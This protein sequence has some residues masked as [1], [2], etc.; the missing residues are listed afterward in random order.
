MSALREPARRWCQRRLPDAAWDRR[1]RSALLSGDARR[2]Q[3]RAC[4]RAY[5]RA[6]FKIRSCRQRA[7]WRDAEGRL[8]GVIQDARCRPLRRSSADARAWQR[9]DQDP[10]ARR[11]HRAGRPRRGVLR[12]AGAP[13]FEP[14][15]GGTKNRCLTTWRRPNG[16]VRTR[17]S[18]LVQRGGA[19]PG[20]VL[21]TPE[22]RGYNAA[23]SSAPRGPGTISEYSAAW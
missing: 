19:S 5:G 13:G 1:V 6:V 9:H 16:A 22:G 12:M 8:R 23:N 14:G 17:F 4:R 10:V 21:E 15:N 7:P 18:R 11:P 2:D 3:R 20:S